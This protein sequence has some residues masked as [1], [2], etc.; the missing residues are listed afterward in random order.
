MLAAWQNLALLIAVDGRAKEAATMAGT[1]TEAYARHYGVDHPET[2]TSRGNLGLIHYLQGQF[3]DAAALQSS[4]LTVRE[5]AHGT[6]SLITAVSR[7]F[8]TRTL[9]RSRRGGP[10]AGE[11]CT[12]DGPAPDPCRAQRAG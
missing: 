12:G 11:C 4:V 1:G 6:D 10:A 5:K 2:L 3:A 9:S 8:L 7:Q